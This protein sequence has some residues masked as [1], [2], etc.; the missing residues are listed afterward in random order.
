MIR[1]SLPLLAVLAGGLA[2]ATPAQAAT[3]CRYLKPAKVKLKANAAQTSV[4]VSWSKPKK[5]PAKLTFRVARDRATIG[6]TR[7]RNMRVKISA[8]KSAKITVTAVLDGRVTRCKVSKRVS[9][10]VDG[11]GVVGGVAVR[12]KD[13][14]HVVLS[15]DAAKPGA[16]KIVRYRVLRGGKTVRQLK[17]RSLTVAI[18]SN[19]TDRYRVAAV[20]ANG[21]VGRA[22]EQ[23]TVKTGHRAPSTPVGLA[24][25]DVTDTEATLSWGAAKAVRGGIS[26]YRVVTAD[27]QTVRA[28]KGTSLRLTG[29]PSAQTRT[30]RVVAV[31]SLG[32]ASATSQ[33]VSFTTGHLPPGT[34]G[35]PGASSVTDTSVSLTWAPAQLPAGSKLRGYRV[36]RD[37]AVVAQVAGPAA[38][39][40]NLA[41]KATYGWSVA[42][43]DTLGYVSAASPA[44]PIAQADPPATTGDAHAFLLA[45]T[46]ASYAAFRKYYTK[47]G[48]VHPTF[49]DC[50]RATAAIEGR[51]DAPIVTYA[52]DR[53]VK[54]LARYNCQ[55]TETVHAILTDQTLRERWLET[56]VADTGRYGY[57]GVSLDFE[58]VAAADRDAL[59][60]FSA[61][62]AARLHA[63]G[64]LLAQAVSGK[65]KDVANHPRSTA[66]DYVELSKHVDYVFV[67][68]WGIHWATSAP[69]AQDDYVWVRQVADYVASLPRKEKFVMGTMLYGMDWPN[70]GGP[71]NEAAGRFY[72]EI[73]AL[74]AQYGVAPVYDPTKD[75]WRLSYTDTSGVP[76]ELWYS[77]ATNVANRLALAR[78]RGLGVGFWRLGQEDARIWDNPIVGG[79]R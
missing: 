50:N 62:L 59:T 49:W 53:K 73:V 4:K 39:I 79:T 1:S 54:V 52:Q 65:T 47:I 36:M 38:D 17:G 15:W 20:D 9:A 37:G 67:M 72:D 63:R 13:D 24:A 30:Y 29:L 70:G 75:S 27:G 12:P 77:D 34:P 21:K 7:G 40:S 42:A 76:H 58:A 44:T 16:A 32:W 68:A 3:S 28:A 10:K 5:A 55:K 69:G 25:S 51:N 74:S 2:L 66:F 33:P 45:S 43:V 78:E 19:R 71:A 46:D 64:K 60:A 23:L 31:D 48:T 18:S 8:G 41:P 11:P 35:A 57:D 14:S 61:E 26:G 56:M 22:S 6:Q